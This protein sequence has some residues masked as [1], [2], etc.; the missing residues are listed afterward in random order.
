MTFHAKY[1]LRGPRVFEV[2]NLA[3]AISTS[4]AARTEGLVA[5]ED[6]KVFD[7]I[8]AGAAAICAIVADK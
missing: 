1:P 2:V 4:E 8:T 7:L 5:G 3:F 6:G